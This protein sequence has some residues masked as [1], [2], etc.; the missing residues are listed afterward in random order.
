MGMHGQQNI[1]FE[2]CQIDALTAL[3]PELFGQ[4]ASP[5]PVTTVGG[6]EWS[7]VYRKLP[8]STAL[9]SSF[10]IDKKVYHLSTLSDS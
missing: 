1:K 7:I 2:S 8:D 3:T 5:L 4:E 10:E 9:K 6:L